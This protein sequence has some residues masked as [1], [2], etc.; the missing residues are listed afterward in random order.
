MLS[1]MHRI[2]RLGN[3]SRTILQ[4][5]RFF[6]HHDGSEL[7]RQYRHQWRPDEK[8]ILYGKD[9]KKPIPKLD[10]HFFDPL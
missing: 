3:L 4:Q 10:K 1:S 9:R 2:C 8:E 6:V 7:P 5:N